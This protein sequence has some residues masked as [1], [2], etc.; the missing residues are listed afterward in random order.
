MK[1]FFKLVSTIVFTSFFSFTTFAQENQ[2]QLKKW[3]YESI[4]IPMNKKNAEFKD[5]PIIVAVIDDA[6]N[7]NHKTIKD[8]IYKNPL[9]KNN[10]SIDEDA[11]GYIEQ[12]TDSDI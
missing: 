5:K 3:A 10:N 12:V 7:I 11:N 4:H 1:I 2:E 9:E 8:F 6:F